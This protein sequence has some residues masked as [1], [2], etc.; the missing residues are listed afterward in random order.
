[1][2][3]GL[4]TKSSAL[5]ARDDHGL[6]A[7]QVRWHRLFGGFGVA[8]EARSRDP[9]VLVDRDLGPPGIIGLLYL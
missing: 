5:V 3:K 9:I 4:V 1:M 7:A 8:G 6:D 2:P